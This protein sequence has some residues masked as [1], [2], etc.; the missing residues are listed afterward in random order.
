MPGSQQGRSVGGCPSLGRFIAP[1]S[2]SRHYPKTLGCPS[3]GRCPRVCNVT[4]WQD[5]G[6]PDARKAKNRRLWHDEGQRCV[7][8]ENASSETPATSCRGFPYPLTAPLHLQ[9]GFRTL[10][11]PWPLR[12]GT[13]PVARRH[14]LSYRAPDDHRLCAAAWLTI[15][16]A[17]APSKKPCRCRSNADCR[18]WATYASRVG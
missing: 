3:F 14:G 18:I 13:A 12:F 1:E 16:S 6:L 9:V 7:E 10:D 15:A 17:S 8:A 2:G 11:A 4:G 5:L